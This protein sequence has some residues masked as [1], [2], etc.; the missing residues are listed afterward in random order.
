MHAIREWRTMDIEREREGSRGERGVLERGE[1]ANEGGRECGGI[2]WDTRTA[3][4]G[5]G[6]HV[7]RQCSGGVG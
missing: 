5:V 6:I 2:R 1:R 7:P 4:F 3:G